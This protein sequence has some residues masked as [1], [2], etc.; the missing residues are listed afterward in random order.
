MSEIAQHIQAILLLMQ[1]TKGP[2]LVDIR[3]AQNGFSLEALHEWSGNRDL[4]T[5]RTREAYLVSKLADFVFIK[6]HIRLNNL[7]YPAR[8]FEDFDE[9]VNWL[10]TV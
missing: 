8:V 9:A 2:V 5:R 7:G 10:K 6:Q 1:D 3:G 4:R